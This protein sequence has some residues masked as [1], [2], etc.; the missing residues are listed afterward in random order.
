MTTFMYGVLIGMFIGTFLGI[1]I[2]GLLAMSRDF[3][4]DDE[5]RRGDG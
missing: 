5:M 4:F 2:M 3:E 1:I